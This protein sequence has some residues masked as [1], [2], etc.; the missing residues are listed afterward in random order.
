MNK[1]QRKFENNAMHHYPV[2]IVA[3]SSSIQIIER[4]RQKCKGEKEEE[5]AEIIEMYIKGDKP[6]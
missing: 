5:I 4:Q 1:F 6:M 3:Q 2:G